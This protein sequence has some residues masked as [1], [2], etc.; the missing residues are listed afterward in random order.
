MANVIL[1]EGL[2]SA[3]SQFGGFSEKPFATIK[4]GETYTYPF[5]DPETGEVSNVVGKCTRIIVRKGEATSKDGE[6][7]EG[8]SVSCLMD[9]GKP[10]FANVREP[11]KSS[12]MDRDEL[13][14]VCLV[15]VCDSDGNKVGGV[16]A[17]FATGVHLFAIKRT[18]ESE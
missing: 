11:Y 3:A 8:A 17:S 15:T 5:A 2:R 10:I 16:M 12:L 6:T 9:N 4:R 18:I 7:F 1:G 13:N 14:S